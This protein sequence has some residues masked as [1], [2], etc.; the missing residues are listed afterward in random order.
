MRLLTASQKFFR[1]QPWE[2]LFYSMDILKGL[3]EIGTMSRHEENCIAGEPDSD[4]VLA[5][6]NMREAFIYAKKCCRGMLSDDDIFSCCYEAL[7]KAAKN[8]KSNQIRFFA[9]AKPYVRGGV[10]SVWKSKDIVKR[11]KNAGL[12][13]EEY[14]YHSEDAEDADGLTGTL[15]NE[16]PRAN[17]PPI[18]DPEIE[19]IQIREEYKLLEP[20]LQSVL[21]DKEQTVIALKYKSGL[22]FQKI[23]ELLD[24]SR[25]D[26]QVTHARAL[27]KLRS[28]AKQ[29]IR[30]L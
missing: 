7:M 8:F 25:P 12:Q 13:L 28:A 20:L 4:T 17:L 19:S 16:K 10:S 24:T 5:L 3:P 14:D 29:K 9:Y 27:K 18:S 2:L 30:L 15:I 11:G 26:I 22:T 23:G 1:Y 6:H 21:T